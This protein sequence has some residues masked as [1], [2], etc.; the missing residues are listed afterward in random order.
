VSWAKLDDGYHMHP[1]VVRAGNA[2]TG[3]HARAV[4]YC[5]FHLT[6]GRLPEEAAVAIQSS[7]VGAIERLLAVG[8]FERI[9]GG[10]L[11]HDYRKYN[12]SAKQVKR[13]RRQAA[14]R[15]RKHRKRYTVT[16]AER[17]ENPGDGDGRRSVSGSSEEAETV[18][19]PRAR[20]KWHRV[21]EGEQLTAA[22]R[23]MAL[24]E[25]VPPA[26][27]DLEWRK[28]LDHRFREARE[29]VD[30]TWRNWCRKAVEIAG[31]RRV[32]EGFTRGFGARRGSSLT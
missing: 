4:S 32:V 11:V 8:L 15:M 26:S 10:Y 14:T 12:P 29:D 27:V 23:A 22:R 2:A 31:N 19:A 7:D 16:S 5:A 25:S 30:A 6:D 24:V 1:K 28:Y 20:A 3:V 13:E 17:T 21:P 18:I 9:P